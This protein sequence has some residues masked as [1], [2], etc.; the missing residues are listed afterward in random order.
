MNFYLYLLFV[1]IENHVYLQNKIVKF[2]FEKYPINLFDIS[3]I[4]SYNY[5][6]EKDT[7][8]FPLTDFF[9]RLLTDDFYFNLTIG[10]PIQIIPAIWNMH[11]YS[12]KIYNNSYNENKSLYFKNLTSPYLYNFDES[13]IALICQDIFHFIDEK[14][15]S[16][17]NE[18]D[19]MLLLEGK[20]NYSF[21]GLQLPDYIADNLLTFPRALKQNKITN[22]YVFF[23]YYN[24]FQDSNEINNYNG[25][26]YF[27]DYP[28]N[29]KE[30][31]NEF[32]E[33]IFS[34]IKAAHRSNL[35]YFDILFDNIYFGKNSDFI[36]IKYKQAEI[37]GNLRLSIGTGEYKDYIS[38]NFFDK[39]EN[40][41]VC[42][43]KTILN[44]TDYLYYECINDKNLFDVSTFPTLKFEIKEINFMLSFNYKDLFFLQNDKI[45]F[46]I[47]FDKYFKLHYSQRWKLG[48]ALF[49]KYLLTFNQDTKMIGIYKKILR[50]YIENDNNNEEKFDNNYQ[51][52]Q[53]N[54][55]KNNYKFPFMKIIII[56]CL[57]IFIIYIILCI[58]KYSKNL[59][60]KNDSKKINFIKGNIA[61]D[62]KDKNII[63]EYYELG[64]NLI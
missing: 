60:K 14:N 10:T 50:N 6:P 24:K 62:S 56:L 44:N 41:S 13:N 55:E 18:L 28:H 58:K 23:I 20:K 34:E 4:K 37:L 17:S 31:N 45:Y 51:N 39:Y 52:N 36:N 53:N 9:Y 12:F 54:N 19:F 43:L 27:G 47:I 15:N 7:K 35:V 49:K 30:F 21:V 29:I 2:K 33:S 46:G 61:H 5:Y 3:L 32:N 40:K 42:N 1:I 38:K 25:E 48:S 64:N 11:R 22:S 63:H 59:F 26:I 8:S 16:F 57:L